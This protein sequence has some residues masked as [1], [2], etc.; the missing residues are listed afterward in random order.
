M[1]NIHTKTE[2]KLIPLQVF[3]LSKS[4]VYI[5]INII[6]KMT[7]AADSTGQSKQQL[8]LINKQR[9]SPRQHS[10]SNHLVAL[11][12]TREYRCTSAHKHFLDVTKDFTKLYEKMR[13]FDHARAAA[14][15][16]TPW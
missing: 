3:Y 11:Q 13:Q 8:L 2:E 5:T 7:R 14:D 6:H 9:T 16:S 1:T 4:R 10:F 15:I 12:Y